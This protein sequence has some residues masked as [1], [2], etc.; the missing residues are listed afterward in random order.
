MNITI[1]PWL[2]LGFLSYTLWSLPPQSSAD[3][4]PMVGTWIVDIEQT[5]ASLDSE[6][7]A[8]GFVKA[9]QGLTEE[10]SVSSTV[11]THLQS[12]HLLCC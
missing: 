5:A 10:E 1:R 3:D 4:F 8:A 12:G 7:K 11:W 6:D 2:I 9:S